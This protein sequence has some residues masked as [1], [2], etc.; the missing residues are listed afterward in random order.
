MMESYALN[1]AKIREEILAACERCGRDASSVSLIAVS[2]SVG[3]DV[4]RQVIACGQSVFGENRWQEAEDKIDQLPSE[5]EWHFIGQ[6]QRNKVR[7]VLPSVRMIHSV[8]SIKLAQ[9]ISR[10]ALEMNI[11]ARVLLQM[12]LAAEKTKA[13]LSEDELMNQWQELLNFPGM[14][15]MGFMTVPPAA[16]DPESS[17]PWFRQLQQI[18]W[19]LQQQSGQA[20]PFLSMGMSDDFSV[21]I[22]EGSTHVRVGTRLFGLR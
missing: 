6:L 4:I 12:N 8:D 21:A 20:L 9:Q 19:Q 7:R 10:V 17:R 1:L 5:L 11:E 15:V 2:K 16:A 22:E 14:K 3:V 18:R 13:G